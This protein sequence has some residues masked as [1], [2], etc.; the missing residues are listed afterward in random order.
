MAQVFAY[1]ALPLFVM[2]SPSFDRDQ[3]QGGLQDTDTRAIIKANYLFNFGAQCDW[4]EEAKQ[5]R[6]EIAVLGNDPVYRSLADTYV[7]KPIGSQVV[8]IIKYGL[9]SEI[10]VPNILYIGEDSLDKL[11]EICLQLKDKSIMV[12]C[13][14]PGA[15]NKGATINFTVDASKIRYELNTEQAVEKGI[16]FG[17]IILQ[18]AVQ[19]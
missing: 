17:T 15:L 12:V 7:G 6:F 2:M 14:Q 4:P 16:T 13:E 19:K 8:E 10:E 5:G 9:A 18:W 1:L 3:N 11:D